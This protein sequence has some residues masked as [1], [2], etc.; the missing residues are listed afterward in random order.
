[1]ADRGVAVYFAVRKESFT[2]ATLM[3]NTDYLN[4]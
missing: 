4:L 3:Y 2:T 1:M